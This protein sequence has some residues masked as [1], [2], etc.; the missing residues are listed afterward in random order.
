MKEAP[1]DLKIQIAR[2]VKWVWLREPND[3]E[4]DALMGLAQEHGLDQVART[5]F[6]TSEFLYIQ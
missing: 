6:N 5:L 2:C 3:L 4:L 1:E